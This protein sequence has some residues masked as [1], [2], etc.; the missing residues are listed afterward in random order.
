MAANPAAFLRCL[1]APDTQ[2]PS[3][4]RFSVREQA[5][6]RPLFSATV[7]AAELAGEPLLGPFV[8]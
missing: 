2:R 7:A 5:L 3:Q 4:L 8:P 6:Q 1:H